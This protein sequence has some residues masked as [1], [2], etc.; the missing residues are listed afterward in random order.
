MSFNKSALIGFVR[1]ISERMNMRRWSSKEI[2][3]RMLD[4][5][6]LEFYEF[7]RQINFKNPEV[8]LQDYR[9]AGWRLGLR[10][11]RFFDEAFYLAQNPDLRDGAEMAPFE[12]YALYGANEGRQPHPFFCMK[13]NHRHVPERSWASITE[14]LSTP[15]QRRKNQSYFFSDR[16][17]KLQVGGVDWTKTDSLEHYIRYGAENG[18]SPF[19][20]MDPDYYAS[21]WM[22]PLERKTMTVLE[23]FEKSSEPKR[24]TFSLFDDEYYNDIHRD[25][26][27][28][29]CPVSHFSKFGVWET[30]SYS[31]LQS[32]AFIRNCFPESSLADRPPI[33]EYLRRKLGRRKRIIFVG[34]DAT[35]TGAP[36][37]LLKLVRQ[38]SNLK[39]IECISILDQAGPLLEDHTRISHTFVPKIG[40]FNVYRGEKSRDDF[41]QALMHLMSQ[42]E[43][44]P[45]IA[46][47]CNSAESRLYASFF[48]GYGVPVITLMHELATFYPESEL[49]SISRSCDLLIFPSEFVKRAMVSR[50]S[51]R[52]RG[53]S[54]G[55]SLDAE[56]AV[57]PQGLLRETYGSRPAGDRDIVFA[58]YGGVASDDVLVTGCGT[59]PTSK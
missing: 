57:I 45:P 43:D 4:I 30:R 59:I 22:S 51:A 18:L 47:F 49:K 5:F 23:H 28:D 50:L 58:P 24:K 38:V 55:D 13:K 36:G 6:D 10:A 17:Y 44:N 27:A 2:L 12:H 35:R 20:T 40:R 53:P 19:P 31:G 8:G 9:Q 48:S 7:Q 52:L 25:I 21:R 39:D 11:S 56:M 3:G 34:H 14:Y 32:E 15:P 37:I 26:G 33:G 46:V 54:D 1:Q 41:E 29:T 16:W 42:L